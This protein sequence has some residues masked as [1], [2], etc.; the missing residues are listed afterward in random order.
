MASSEPQLC[1]LLFGKSVDGQFRATV[2]QSTVFLVGTPFWVGLNGNQR[3]NTA[4]G[5][6]TFKKLTG[7]FLLLPGVSFVRKQ[8]RH[9]PQNTITPPP[10]SGVSLFLSCY[11][12]SWWFQKD[13]ENKTDAILGVQ[14]LKFVDLGEALLS[15]GGRSGGRIVSGKRSGTALEACAPCRPGTWWPDGWAPGWW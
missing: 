12:F 15:K 14:I 7:G 2:V 6:P 10:R 1:N 5:G 8:K 13:L 11:P 4:F 3:K 9:S